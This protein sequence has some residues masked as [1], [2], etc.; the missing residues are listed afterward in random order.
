MMTTPCFCHPDVPFYLLSAM[1]TCAQEGEETA[2]YHLNSSTG[3]LCE[4]MIK[5]LANTGT[6][7]PINFILSFGLFPL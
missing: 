4:A 6:K 7:S 1:M 3:L 2:F 5:Y